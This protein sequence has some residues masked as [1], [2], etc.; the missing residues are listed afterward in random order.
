MREIATMNKILFIL[1][2]FCLLVEFSAEL[3]EGVSKLKQRGLK[4]QYLHSPG[5]RPG[6]WTFALS[7]RI[8][9]DF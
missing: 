7:G 3:V 5:Q 9:Y 8:D 1:L 6:L 2:F 4:A